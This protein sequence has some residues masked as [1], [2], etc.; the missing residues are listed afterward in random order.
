MEGRNVMLDVGVGGWMTMRCEQRK[1]EKNGLGIEEGFGR[2]I[3]A[4][5][6]F[7]EMQR[8]SR[9]VRPSQIARM[10]RNDRNSQKKETGLLARILTWSLR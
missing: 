1:I 10:N 5:R 4:M 8:G 7:S 2:C 6:G 9:D 3:L